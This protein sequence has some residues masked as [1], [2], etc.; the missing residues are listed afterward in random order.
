MLGLRKNASR[1]SVVRGVRLTTC[2]P[3]SVTRRNARSLRS[4]GT[5]FGFIASHTVQAFFNPDPL[6]TT[7][8]AFL[9]L[10]FSGCEQRRP[11]E[12]HEFPTG[13]SGWAIVVWGR[14]NYPALPTVGDKRVLRFPADG[15]I[16]TSTQ[17]QFGWAS[18]KF[19]FVDG[20]GQRSGP[21][22]V[23]FGATGSVDRGGYTMQFTTHF[24]G[25]AADVKAASNSEST[26]NEAFNRLYSNP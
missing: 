16:I 18:D 26:V 25:T 15:I 22:R 24:V 8:L 13:F 11:V 20:A 23:P 5:A 4:E 10:A 1:G 19:F 7:L 21:A 2:S 12:L 17:R 14:S 9:L 3:A 6:K